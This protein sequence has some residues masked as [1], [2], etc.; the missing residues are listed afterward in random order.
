MSAREKEDV[1][2]WEVEGGKVGAG[3]KTK[4]S[5]IKSKS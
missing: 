3:Q 5:R 1:W 2:L 4:V